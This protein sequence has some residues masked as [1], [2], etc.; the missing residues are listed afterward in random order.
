MF[1]FIQKI[2]G[3][4]RAL[5]FGSFASN[6][7]IKVFQSANSSGS[8]RKVVSKFLLIIHSV[9]LLS[10]LDCW[11]SS[12]IEDGGRDGKDTERR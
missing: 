5:I 8:D 10:V 1:V 3:K 4:T 2:V 6:F 7:L 12:I 11:H 9:H